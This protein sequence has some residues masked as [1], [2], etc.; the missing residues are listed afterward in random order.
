MKEG[1]QR[2]GF[3]PLGRQV[4]FTENGER[5]ANKLSDIEIDY[6][7]RELIG[8]Q[9][10]LGEILEE[11]KDVYPEFYRAPRDYDY[12]TVVLALESVL[13]MYPELLKRRTDSV[14]DNLLTRYPDSFS[15]RKVEADEVLI[16]F[17]WIFRTDVVEDVGPV[18]KL[19]ALSLFRK[20]P[21]N[22][23]EGIRLRYFDIAISGA[24]EQEVADGGRYAVTV[25][26]A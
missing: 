23:Q 18:T 26:R 13:R 19:E 9:K 12:S 15:G 8:D 20:L 4:I 2:I 21:Q 25:K 14:A 10:S 24:E 11:M 22:V 5:I 3:D 17:D 16:C 7:Q 1:E 6:I